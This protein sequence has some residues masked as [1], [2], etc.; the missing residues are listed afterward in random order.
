M[1]SVKLDEHVLELLKV[2]SA[3]QN[4]SQGQQIQ[5]MIEREARALKLEV[6]KKSL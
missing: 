4:R 1:I 6:P 5:F 2:L 3:N